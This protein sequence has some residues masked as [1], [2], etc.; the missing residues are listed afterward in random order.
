MGINSA[1]IQDS[2]RFIEN[3]I[4]IYSTMRKT[5]LNTSTSWL[6]TKLRITSTSEVQRWI[7]SPVA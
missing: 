2:L 1:A 6:H 7:I 4:D 3:I 5:V